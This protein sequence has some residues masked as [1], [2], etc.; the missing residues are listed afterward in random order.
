MSSQEYRLQGLTCADCAK[1]FEKNIRNI[2]TVDD[3]ILNFGASKVTVSG[4]V[5]TEDLEKA[6]AFDN[7][8]V[9]EANQNSS[10]EKVPFFK[11]R[12]NILM[13]TSLIFLII[14]YTS[15][16]T[17]GAKSS[18]TI[19]LFA[20]AILVGG[21]DMFRTGLK[22]LSKFIFDMKTLMT[23]AV[24]GA[25]IIGEWAEGAAVVFLFGVSEA[26][27]EYSI[28]KARQSIHS[29]MDIAPNVA[30]VRR[31]K[32]IVERHVDDIKIS[33]IMVIKPGEKLPMDGQVIKGQTSINQ[34]AI[35]G[36][37]MPV[38]KTKGDEVFA[39]TLNEEGSIE[40]MVTKLVED[41]TIAKIIHLVEEAQAEKAPAQ[42]FVDQFAKYYTPAIII[43][44][45]LV[46][47]IPPIFLSG[48][49][50]HWVYLGLAT[51]VVGC[52]CA[53][54][55]STPVAI[56]TAIGNAAKNGVLIK[57]GVHLEETGQLD[58]IAFDKTGTLTNGKP[59]VT[60]IIPLN[61]QSE[62]EILKIATAIESFSQHPIASAII[63]K[64]KAEK[65]VALQATDF[66]SITGMGA[67]ANIDNEVYYIGS[68]KLFKNKI[69]D[70]IQIEEITRLQTEGNTVMILGTEEDLIGIIA[71][72]DKIRDKSISVIKQLKQ[73]GIKHTIMLTGDNQA[74]GQTIANQL[75]IDSVKAELL[76][77]EKLNEISKLKKHYGRVAMVGDGIN[78]A[79]ALASASVGIAMGG[80]GTDAALETADIALMADDLNKLP[81]TVNL[82]RRA[83]QIIKQNI[84]FALGLKIIALLLVIP[85]LL[86]LWI[87]IIADVGATILVVLNSMRL[88]RT[89]KF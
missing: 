71:V 13:L 77:E 76:P 72:A 51:L 81:Y 83:V 24:I 37:S 15:S 89:N 7:I 56:V 33:D 25:A 57:G 63:R 46:A 62:A 21:F 27:E 39:G 58:A 32:N 38:Y 19:G 84:S 79:P 73:L 11:N 80:G 50:S 69:N 18:I 14:G 49:W 88:I 17:L 30:F 52:P 68:P 31:G 16:F 1:Q 40:V 43:I 65:L 53:L 82:S 4:D 54:V 66:Q 61:K 47:I 26:L 75:G 86:T 64:S 8:K 45:I 2:D 74:T 67:Q 36:E 55:I 60:Q 44:A 70:S 9:I 20:T 34:A 59:E 42:K 6:G 29:L 22:N 5:T 78:D 12:Q 23:I 10:F 35:T 48:D 3:V 85:G 41:T 28:N 87:A